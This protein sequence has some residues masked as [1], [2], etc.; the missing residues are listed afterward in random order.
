VTTGLTIVTDAL[1]SAGIAAQ[2]DPIAAEDSSL[3][4]RIL[5]RMMDSWSNEKQMM[6]ALIPQTFPMVAGQQTYSSTAFTP[7]TRPVKIDSVIV[8]LSNIDY[9]VEIID[10]SSFQAISYKPVNSVPQVMAITPTYPT[11]TLDFWPRPYAVFT[12]T[13]QVYT[14]LPDTIT[15]TTTIALPPGYEDA[16]VSNLA[17][18]CAPRWGRQIDPL[19]VREAAN[20]RRVLKR[21]NYEAPIMGG[22]GATLEQ[23]SNGFIS[24]GWR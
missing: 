9:D 23:V 15:E 11:L 16:L 13:L 19:I 20:S 14:L 5:N 21:N 4:L 6:Y 24:G 3:A 18:R 1:I 2:G 7:A 10:T 22:F 8:S 17:V 12:C